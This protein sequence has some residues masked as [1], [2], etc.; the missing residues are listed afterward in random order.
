MPLIKTCE[1][2]G[3][4]FKVPPSDSKQRFCSAECGNKS[5]RV[6]TEYTCE[7]CGNSFTKR[8]KRQEGIKY[9]SN[10]C[11]FRGLENREVRHCAI[12]GNEVIRAKSLNVAENVTCSKECYSKLC[13][14]LKSGKQHPNYHSIDKICP[15]C[16]KKYQV[17]QSVDDK[18]E[19]KTCSMECRRI[20]TKDHPQ[21]WKSN[22]IRQH[23]QEQR[24]IAKQRD[25]NKCQ[26]CGAT[27]RLEVHHIRKRRLFDGDY[28]T[29]DDASNLITYCH[30]CH[31]SLEPRI[32]KK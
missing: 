5:R 30:T 29:A 7:V 1:M 21:Q 10:T 2:C 6:V 14:R 19:G 9:C 23:L 17:P 15:V 22:A 20:F 28:M 13:S 32:V 4:E 11:K 24:K 18:G 25:D 8:G 16:G 26:N 12:C 31:L 3:K 27:Q